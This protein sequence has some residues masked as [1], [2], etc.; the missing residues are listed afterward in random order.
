MH[1][2]ACRL[3]QGTLHGLWPQLCN[4]C[5]KDFPLHCSN[6]PFDLQSIPQ[7]TVDKMRVEWP[8]YQGG[9]RLPTHAS[10]HARGVQ[11][12]L[13]DACAV[14]HHVICS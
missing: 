10:Q 12:L 6:K 8:S 7:A 11:G 14:L 5:N 9:E 13:T 3:P 1:V 2:D 4:P